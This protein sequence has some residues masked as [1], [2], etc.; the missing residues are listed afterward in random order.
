M[1]NRSHDKMFILTTRSALFVCTKETKWPNNINFIYTILSAR[2]TSGRW[3]YFIE[4]AFWKRQTL[5]CS[6]LVLKKTSKS[7]SKNKAFSVLHYV[8]KV[9]LHNLNIALRFILQLYYSATSQPGDSAGLLIGKKCHNNL[10]SVPFCGRP[11]P[12]DCL[13]EVSLRQIPLGLELQEA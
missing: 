3:F 5:K 4:F 2:A 9:T 10:L 1:S 11:R 8:L 13:N 12:P 7:L 6:N